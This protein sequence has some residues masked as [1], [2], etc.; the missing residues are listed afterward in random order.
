MKREDQ[1]I[2]SIQ[3]L[4]MIYSLFRFGNEGQKRVKK[5]V[6]LGVNGLNIRL[7]RKEN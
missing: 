5:S 3:G 1:K 7:I 6:I 2:L 4:V